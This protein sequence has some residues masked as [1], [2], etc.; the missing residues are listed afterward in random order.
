MSAQ[1][2][3]RRLREE[4]LDGGVHYA[5]W[6]GAGCSISSGIPGAATLVKERWL[7][8]L[9]ELKGG[10]LSDV[11]G[12]AAT[13]FEGYDPA[14]PAAVYG[15]VIEKRFPHPAGRQREFERICERHKPGFG[16]SVLAALISRGD[17]MFHVALTTNFDDLI[18][19]AMYHFSP[20]ESRPLVIP[21]GALARYI[22]PTAMRPLVVK[23][24]GDFR[25]SPQNTATETA[26]LRG[27]LSEGIGGLLHDRGVIFV[28]YGG[29]DKGI[30][31]VLKA[32]PEEALPHGVWWA[33]RE[34][35]RGALREWLEN[36]RAVWVEAPGFDEL[37]LVFKGEFEIENP[38]RTRFDQ[39]FESYTRTYVALQ[40]K[41]GSTPDSDTSAD[42]LKDAAARAGS[43]SSDWTAPFFEASGVAEQDPNEAERIYREAMPRFPQSGFLRAGLGAL[44]LR[45][46]RYAEGLEWLTEAARM[47]PDNSLVANLYG[48]AMALTGHRD[49]ALVVFREAL[50]RD[51]NHVGLRSNLGYYLCRD[52]QS[53]AAEEEL[54]TILAQNLVTSEEHAFF[55]IFLAEMGWQAEA[56]DQF[57][58]AVVEEPTDAGHRA[59]YARTLIALGRRGQAL[60]EIEAGLKV[61]TP[62]A[63]TAQL[64]LALYRW[65]ITPEPASTES[66]SM[67]KRLLTEGARLPEWNLTDVV[68]AAAEKDDPEPEWTA[69]LARVINGGGDP[70]ELDGW[71]AWQAA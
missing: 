39:L 58:L 13:E 41:V 33:G 49:E 40:Q 14:D 9:C 53:G 20:D 6:L 69:N 68:A 64:E 10:D 48:V 15:P 62:P 27:G 24:H 55:G 59:N 3:V 54:R 5:F 21:D 44:L 28:G 70:A 18:L 57:E 12:W 4:S 17:G 11:D 16:Y 1:E 32:L 19:E 34:E 7:P 50:T 36:R 30:A 23:I 46:A 47:E 37:M 43:A 61:L 66:L 2:F 45:R 52:G 67:V 65:A 8:K 63:V 31:E 60:E 38:T 26:V 42:S 51:P 22:R 29:N 71:D 25:L 56:A 35:P